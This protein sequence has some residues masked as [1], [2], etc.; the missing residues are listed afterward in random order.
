MSATVLRVGIGSRGDVDHDG[1]VHL[2]GVSPSARFVL[3]ESAAP[4]CVLFWVADMRGR[5]VRER[6]RV[7]TERFLIFRILNSVAT[8]EIHRK[9]ITAPKILKLCV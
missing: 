5:V 9:I 8:L 3:P 7:S 6:E 4:P 2:A 1:A